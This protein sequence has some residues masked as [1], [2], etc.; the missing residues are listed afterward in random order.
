MFKSWKLP[1]GYHYNNFV[2]TP[3]SEHMMHCCNDN[4]HFTNKNV[5]TCNK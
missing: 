4:V 2:A 1:P 3:A 5:N